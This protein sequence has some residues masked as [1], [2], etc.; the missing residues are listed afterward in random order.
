M[1]P[2]EP[3]SFL[4]PRGAIFNRDL[5]KVEPVDLTQ[6]TEQIKHSWYE[7][8]PKGLNPASGET[9]PKFDKY[10]TD[11]RYSWMKAPRYKTNRW[12]SV[13]WPACWSLTPRVLLQ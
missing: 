13:P 9:K 7:G 2:K 12:K 11:A 5:A 10:D 4:F 6:I 8:E 3:D 1:G